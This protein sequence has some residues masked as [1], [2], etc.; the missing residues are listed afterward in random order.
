MSIK[1][2]GIALVSLMLALAPAKAAVLISIQEVGADVVANGSGSIDTGG[3]TVSG[4]TQ[5][6]EYEVINAASALIGFGILTDN[7]NNTFHFAIYSGI[8]GPTSF[9][10]GIGLTKPGDTSSGAPFVLTGAD[11]TIDL[12]EGYV[13]DTF[14]TD[15]DIWHNKTFSSLG[16]TPG[17]YTYTFGS[18]ANAD[19]IVVQIGPVP[20]LSTWAMMILGFAGIGFLTY[21]RRRVG[22]RLAC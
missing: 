17:T 20:E 13:S 10:P 9:G 19:S 3:L 1:S 4:H 21:R 22:L 7:S 2:I 16:L 14:F 12:P 15:M 6:G 11:G 8:S 5:L 18:D